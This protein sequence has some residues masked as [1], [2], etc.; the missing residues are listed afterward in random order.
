MI[1]IKRNVKRKSFIMRWMKKN[2]WKK[3]EDGDYTNE[4]R[5]ICFDN[6][7]FELC[8][9]EVYSQAELDSDII[10]GA[11]FGW[12][13]AWLEPMTDF[14]KLRVEYENLEVKYDALRERND[15]V[16]KDFDK[17]RGEHKTLTQSMKDILNMNKRRKNEFAEM[18]GKWKALKEI[19]TEA[20]SG[21]K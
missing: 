8:G 12:L 1:T 18:K 3:D 15:G 4:E 7:M 11:N 5:D 2:E 20:M 14:D 21:R 17:L 10:E 16:E 6:D 9:K 13:E 19:L